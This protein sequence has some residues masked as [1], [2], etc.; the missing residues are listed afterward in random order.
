MICNENKTLILLS[1]LIKKKNVPQIAKSIYDNLIVKGYNNLLWLISVDNKIK[2]ENLDL[3][4]EYCQKYRINH[5][6]EFHGSETEKNYGG[7][8]FNDMLHTA[9]EFY[10]KKGIDPWVYILDDDNII[11]P[12]MGAQLESMIDAAIRSN[13]KAIWMSMHRE[14]GFIDTVR[15]YSIYGRGVNNQWTYADEF[16]PDPSQLLMR[17]SLIN[18]MGYFNEGATYDQKLWWYFYNN[19]DKICLPEEWHEGHW[20][21]R[22]NNNFYQCYHNAI[23]DEK[24]VKLVNAAID[25]NEP[26]SFSFVVGL[27]ES[28]ERFI[29]GREDGIEIFNKIKNKI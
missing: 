7:T 9:Y 14:D 27:N 20:L 3:I 26:M 29:I 25:N 21:G 22:G 12:L 4:E 6:T 15:S 24:I 2:N 16:M 1:S 23:N 18:E 10:N 11:C 17:L 19:L 5:L 13:K 8:M 28:C